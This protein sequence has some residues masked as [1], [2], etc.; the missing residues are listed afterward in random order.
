MALKISAVNPTTGQTTSEAYARIT[1]FFGTKDQIQ[2][3]VAIH[4]SEDARTGNMQTIKENAHYIAVEDLQGNL[5]NH[6]K[7]QFMKIQQKLMMKS[8]FHLIKKGLETMNI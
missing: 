6:L 8:S 4:A 7:A 1:N 5:I 2:V 3:Q